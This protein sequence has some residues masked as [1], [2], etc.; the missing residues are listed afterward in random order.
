MK[1]IDEVYVTRRQ[2]FIRDFMTQTQRPVSELAS[3][4]VAFDS[5]E[6][7]IEEP[8]PAPAP[9]TRPIKSSKP[10]MAPAVIHEGNKPNKHP[11]AKMVAAEFE[12]HIDYYGSIG[13]AA[14]RLG[15]TR[16]QLEYALK[17]KKP[18]NGI[19]VITIT[20]EEAFQMNGKPE[21]IV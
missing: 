3:F 10:K 14:Q 6:R 20:P 4:L 17:H 8:E 11:R 12:G 16:K 2:W 13:A 15:V 7:T 18:I 1:A 19:S 5:C 9:V 21:V